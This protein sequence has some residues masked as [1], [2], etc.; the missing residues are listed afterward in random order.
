MPKD[1]LLG[2]RKGQL[3]SIK[4]KEDR[5]GNINKTETP[6]FYSA[7]YKKVPCEFLKKGACT[8]GDQCT[9]SHD[10]EPAKSSTICR[11]FL[12]NACD[13]GDNCPFSHEIDS[14]PCK[15]YFA[16]QCD[17]HTLCP[18]S[19]EDHRFFKGEKETNQF[20]EE[21]SDFMQESLRMNGN[22][23]KLT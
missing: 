17:K 1:M 7:N 21:N 14:Y 2:N 11:F 23:G 3:D 18:F 16:R 10:F 8:R 6:A 15:F 22:A 13:K 5:K 12:G 20:I 4:D 19:H 9:F